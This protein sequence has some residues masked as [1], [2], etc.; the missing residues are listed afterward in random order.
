M[1]TGSIVYLKSNPDTKMT[2]STVFGEYVMTTW[3]NGMDMPQNA[4]FHREMLGEVLR[5]SK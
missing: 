4:T 2:V 5:P 1:K 3:F